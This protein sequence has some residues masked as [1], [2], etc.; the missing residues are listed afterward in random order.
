MKPWIISWDIGSTGCKTCLYRVDKGLELHSGALA[1]YSLHTGADGKAEQDPEDWWRAMAASTPRVL[2]LA[3]VRPEDIGGVSFCAQMQGLVLVDARGR[4][5]RPA[6]SYMDT[7]ARSQM[8]SRFGRGLRIEGVPLPSLLRSL[9]INGAVAAS[10]KDPVW[11][12]LWVRDHEPQTFEKVHRWL[13]VKDYLAG[14]ATGEWTMS[15]DSGFATFLT[16]QRRIPSTWSPSLARMY[17]V[18]ESHLPR[19]VDATECV[20]TLTRESAAEL[21]LA[22]GIP[23]YSGGGDASMIALGAGAME[24]GDTHVYTGTSGWV[25]TA[26]TK[27][28]VDV[29]RHMAAIVGSRP[30]IYHFFGEQETAGKCLEWVR[31]HLALDEIGLYLQKVPVTEGPEGRY[32]SLYEFLM[33]EIG[34]VAPGSGGVLFAPWLH[35]SRAPFEDPHAR[36]MFWGLGLGTGKR[37]MIR[38]VVEGVIYHQKW[39]LEGIRANHEVKGSLRFVGGGAL[40]P[41]MAR[42][43]ADM[44]EYPVETIRNPQNAGAGGAALAAAIGMGLAGFGQVRDM[45]PPEATFE[46]DTRTRDTYREGFARFRELYRSTRHLA[47]P[48][49]GKGSAS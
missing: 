29:G 32:V 25:S 24:P 12:Y 20:G 13:D 10:V 37:A 21:G 18:E 28:T 17:G 5:L 46:P 16:D 7:R 33:D 49:W 34:Q 3:G 45:V 27:Q 35:G 22:P 8:Q 43:L 23:V 15:R 47:T 11:K 9:S 30:G 14:R 1:G 42:I 4:A 39:L 40:S 44:M 41:R 36:G 48:A 19:L 31:D 6:M 2:S 38:A 26:V